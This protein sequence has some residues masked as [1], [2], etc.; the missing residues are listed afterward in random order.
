MNPCALSDLKEASDAG[1]ASCTSVPTPISL[2][3]SNRAPIC[4]A[5]SWIPGNPQVSSA[6]ALLQHLRINTCAVISDT[7]PK[8]A[9]I[10][11][12][13]SLDL[14]RSRVLKSVCWNFSGDSVH[15]VVA[16]RPQRLTGGTMRFRRLARRSGSSQTT[17][18]DCRSV[19]PPL[20][21]DHRPRGS[22][23]HGAS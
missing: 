10:V 18:L 2:E 20:P 3:T 7:Q 22:S 19:P 1:I 14:T 5:R 8:C 23:K 15:F 13:F 11:P 9:K 6:L 17:P 4:S 16:Q 21:A 12:D